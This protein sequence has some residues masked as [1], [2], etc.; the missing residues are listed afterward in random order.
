MPGK[1]QASNRGKPESSKERLSSSK[2]R[3][4]SKKN[5]HA[6]INLVQL[7]VEFVKLYHKL[8][9]TYWNSDS[10]RIRK[11]CIWP[12]WTESDGD[13]KQ[14]Q[15]TSTKGRERGK[16]SQVPVVSCLVP[17]KG[18]LLYH[19][20]YPAGMITVSKYGRGEPGLARVPIWNPAHHLTFSLCDVRYLESLNL[21][22]VCMYLSSSVLWGYWGSSTSSVSTGH[23]KCLLEK[24]HW[25]ELSVSLRQ[26]GNNHLGLWLTC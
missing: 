13:Q 15:G 21:F 16:A 1:S 19:W 3:W 8:L 10:V 6:D 18:P 22:Y 2:S 26:W 12:A 17:I 23:R 14:D 4:A 11:V 7:F 9:P 24:I 20:S 25:C 5:M